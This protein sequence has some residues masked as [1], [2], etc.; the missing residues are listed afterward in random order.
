[1][2]IYEYKCKRCRKVT[3]LERPISAYKDPVR[4][5]CGKNAKLVIPKSGFVLTDGD[6]KWLESSKATLPEEAKYI[7]TRGEHRR[8]LRDHNLVCIG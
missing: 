5:S 7:R 1:M 6:V 2:P 8:Y 3:E 4:C